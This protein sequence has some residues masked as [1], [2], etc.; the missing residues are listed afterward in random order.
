MFV[1][2]PYELKNTAR[3]VI[4]ERHLQLVKLAATVR[5]RSYLSLRFRVNS[6]SLETA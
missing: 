4:D 1:E 6:D 2:D 3:C 5:I